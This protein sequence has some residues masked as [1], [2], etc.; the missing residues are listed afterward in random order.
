MTRNSIRA[1]SRMS[2][3]SAR[4]LLARAYAG[5]VLEAM[6]TG[7]SPWGESFSRSNLRLLCIG[8]RC[9]MAFENVLRHPCQSSGVFGNYTRILLR[10]TAFLNMASFNLIIIADSR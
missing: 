6:Q 2:D 10:L 8:S 1:I 4:H 9:R 7:H 3:H 5:F